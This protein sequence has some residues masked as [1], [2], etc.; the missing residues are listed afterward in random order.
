MTRNAILDPNYKKKNRG[1]LSSTNET[2]RSYGNQVKNYEGH[3][4]V[5]SVGEQSCKDERDDVLNG[6]QV[7]SCK[8][9]S[10]KKKNNDMMTMVHK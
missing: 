4:P 10:V 2:S 1:S 8:N 5:F 9:S 3:Q 7:G 6:D